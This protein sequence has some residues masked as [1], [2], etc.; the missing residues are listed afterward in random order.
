MMILKICLFINQHLT[1]D[2]ENTKR[3]L[4]IL[5]VANQ[6]GYILPILSHYMDLFCLNW[7]ILQKNMCKPRQFSFNYRAKQL[8]DKN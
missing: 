3:H 5:L 8:F 1:H 4:K 2:K 6:R 7:N